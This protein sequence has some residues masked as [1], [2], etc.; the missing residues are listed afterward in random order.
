MTAPPDLSDE[1]H[2]RPPPAAIPT[3]RKSPSLHPAGS[4]PALRAS[5]HR[6]SNTEIPT[7]FFSSETLPQLHADSEVTGYDSR[8][9]GR[10]PAENNTTRKKIEDGAR[11]LADWFQGK[12]EPVS[13]GMVGDGDLQPVNGTT[14][15][16][17]TG[18]EDPNAEDDSITYTTRAQQRVPPTSPLKQMTTATSRFPFFGLTQ[19]SGE[20]QPELPEPA[21]DEFLNLDVSEA[22]YRTNS[23]NL[24]AEEAFETLRD[25]ADALLRRLQAA[26]KQRT[27]AHHEAL[28]D[29]REK[30]EEY[31]ETRTRIGHLKT[32]LD[33]MAGKVLEQ[34][35]AIQ[36]MAEELKQARQ[37]AEE[38]QRRSVVLLTPTDDEGTSE[39]GKD[40]QIARRQLKRCSGGTFTS[41]SGFESGDESLAESIWS[42]RDT[43]MSTS[44]T[45]A[46]AAPV[47][48]TTHIVH[49]ATTSAPG[50]PRFRDL[51]PSSTPTRMSAYD[52]VLR[53]LASTSLA[54][55]LKGNSSK[56]TICHGVPASEAWSVMGILKEEN[57][58]L[59]TRLIELE[60]VVDDCLSIVG[61]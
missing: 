31:E 10:R 45:C 44:S 42:R 22:L 58:G 52:R 27:F 36:A 57:S 15:Q 5:S 32:Q 47:P 17:Q 59:K 13:W 3:G 43:V 2:P 60:S 1:H 54:N 40:L 53:G 35:K 16:H 28:A 48:A 20:R 19:R 26:Y 46:S 49:S 39:S 50:Q 4:R 55:S 18:A 24:S 37:Q 12:S 61:P 29:K 25:T 33:D 41:D 9:L 34:Q 7:R 56:C 51:S 21:D 38:A 11:L 8:T 23:D 14:S 6:R 30:Q